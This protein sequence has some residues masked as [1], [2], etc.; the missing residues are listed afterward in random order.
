MQQIKSIISIFVLSIS[1]L[2]FSQHKIDS[3]KIILEKEVLSSES[4]IDILNEIGYRYWIVDSKESLKY[5]EQG[6]KLADS[7]DFLSGQAK[8]NRVL[9]VAHWSQGNHLDAIKHLNKALLQ[10]ENLPDKEGI[11]NTTLNLAM[12]YAAIQ[13]DDKALGMYEDAI[14]QF[15]ALNLK[16]R[17]ATAYTKIGSLYINQNK[18]D[19][20]K[21]HLT[22]ALMIHTEANFNYGIAEAHNRLGVMY[23]KLKEKEQA[24]YHIEKSIMY[25]KKVNDADGMTSNLIQYGK[26]LVLDNQFKPAEQ[27]LIL[28]IN[29]AKENNL[30]RY[31]LEAYNE[32]KALKRLEGKQEEAL[33][34]FDKYVALKDSLY[35]SE[36]TMRISALE[37]NNELKTKEKELELLAEKERSNN[38]VKW[39]LISGL[40]A[41]M[42]ITIIYFINLKKRISQRRE[43]HLTKEEFNKTELENAK[44]KQQ[45]LRQQLDYKNKE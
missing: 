37:F 4:K 31:E 9:G 27:H 40:V 17:I 32:L 7:L 42:L 28:A 34:Y 45:E 43:L 21:V 35:N 10:Y 6:L 18:L 38:F 25:G 36:K 16:G 15:T 29:R 13:E 8:A 23:V 24:Y 30:K 22:N 39:S 20:A 41:L 2:C 44:L 11:A 12:V 33:V 26:L 3:L 14:N 19:V 5:G 1:T